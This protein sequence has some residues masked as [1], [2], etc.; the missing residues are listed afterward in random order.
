MHHETKSEYVEM[1][2]LTLKLTFRVFSEESDFLDS[3][4]QRSEGESRAHYSS[5]I[6]DAVGHGLCSYVCLFGIT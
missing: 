3:E 6:Y 2:W 5:T 1:F 4:L